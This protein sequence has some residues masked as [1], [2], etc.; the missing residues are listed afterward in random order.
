MIT[1]AYVREAQAVVNDPSA[2]VSFHSK[3]KGF[4]VRYLLPGEADTIN[5]AVSA[6]IAAMA[7]SLWGDASSNMKM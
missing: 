4:S 5:Q 2:A 6:N 1:R 3:P 7:R